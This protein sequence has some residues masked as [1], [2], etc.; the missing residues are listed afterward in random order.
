MTCWGIFSWLLSV[1]CFTGLQVVY[2][3][4]EGNYSRVACQSSGWCPSASLQGNIQTNRL[5]ELQNVSPPLQLSLLLHFVLLLQAC[6]VK[7]EFRKAE[8]LIKHAVFLARWPAVSNETQH[9]SRSSVCHDSNCFVCSYR[10]HFGHK[11]PKYSDTLLDYG[12]Y[13]LNV[14]NIC[15]SVAI[16]Q[17]RKPLSLY[18]HF[19]LKSQTLPLFSHWIFALCKETFQ[20]VCSLFIL[21]TCEGFQYIL[22]LILYILCVSRYQ[23]AHG[24]V[25]VPWGWGPLVYMAYWIYSILTL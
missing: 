22:Y 15:Q 10:E 6:V 17:V 23:L 20:Y 16:Y 11:H 4:H 25:P 18:T 24:L 2:R 5:H 12:F 19:F 7:R 1:F 21:Q 3:G 13:L 8:Q 14:D 9:Y